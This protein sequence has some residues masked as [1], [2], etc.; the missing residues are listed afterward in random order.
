MVY[1]MV[2]DTWCMAHGVWHMVYDTWCMTH[3]VWHMVYDMTAYSPLASTDCDTC[4][5]VCPPS[6][7]S[8]LTIFLF[9]FPSHHPPSTIPLFYQFH[10]HDHSPRS[11]LFFQFDIQGCKLWW[12][13]GYGDQNLYQLT[14]TYEP[15]P[16]DAIVRDMADMEH[17]A[18][19]VSR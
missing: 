9:P 15:A 18:S 19:S 3:G 6:Y 17:Y 5:C 12:P 11:P 13:A 16:W 10:V 2:Y 8:I 14:V 4:R 1:V 7:H